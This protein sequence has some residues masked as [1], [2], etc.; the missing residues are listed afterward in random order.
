VQIS[1]PPGGE[2]RARA[3][4]ADALG[5]TEVEKPEPLRGRGGCWFRWV[6]SEGRVLAEV[7]V[8][9]EPGFRP[10]RKAH[11]ALLVDDLDA[12]VDRL[13]AAS[14]DVDESERETF[15]GYLRVHVLDPFGNRV[16]LVEARGNSQGV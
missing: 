2:N 3:F 13:R 10:A 4:W 5:L 11:P 9:A 8:G 15:P 1:C 7:H 16:E 14:Y 6:S 12:L